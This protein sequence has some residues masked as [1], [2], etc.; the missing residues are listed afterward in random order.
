M[1][2]QN[3]NH[4]TKVLLLGIGNFAV[5]IADLINDIPNFNIAGFVVNR[6]P[7]EPGQK[8]LGKPV[9]WI[10]E[11]SVLKDHVH[12]L[13]ASGT[14]KRK[15]FIKKFEDMGFQFTTIVHPTARISKLSIVKHGSIISYGVQIGAQTQIGRHV[16]IN[17]GASWVTMSASMIM[18]RFPPEQTWLQKLSLKNK[19]VLEWEQT[20]FRIA[21]LVL[22]Q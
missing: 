3:N 14:T 15:D 13:S 2:I 22:E 20:L 5:E 21:Q 1:A 11:I 4:I 12:A 9:Y 17:R 19:H 8:L 6:P 7:F 10:D 16:H 18:Q